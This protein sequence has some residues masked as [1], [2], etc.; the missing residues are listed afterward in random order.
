MTQRPDRAVLALAE[1]CR[2]RDDDLHRAPRSASPAP[3]SLS[4]GRGGFNPPPPPHNGV[5]RSHSQVP[6]D[7][8]APA[9]HIEASHPQSHRDRQSEGDGSEYTAQEMWLASQG[10]N[11]GG[12]GSLGLGFEA[13]GPRG[14][15]TQSRGL[16]TPG[17]GY[18]G[19]RTEPVRHEDG[20]GSGSISAP[21]SPHRLY[22][23]LEMG[24]GPQPSQPNW[25]AT[26]L[27][28]DP[29]HHA[30]A[31][32]PVNPSSSHRLPARAATLATGSSTVPRSDRERD[33][34]LPLPAFSPFSPVGAS[35]T[36]QPLNG[37][38]ASY[39]SPSTLLSPPHDTRALP[40]GNGG[41]GLDVDSLA[42]S[43]GMMGVCP[44][45]KGAED[46]SEARE[47]QVAGNGGPGARAKTSPSQQPAL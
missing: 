8:L 22:A 39:I 10:P 9:P 37:E 32:M 41:P 23:Q 43:F 30:T 20:A 21:L 47:V 15:D 17:G 31:G 46:P 14:R 16:E 34:T 1:L 2:E 11:L 3:R 35:S 44:P 38:P 12:V 4:A 33:P 26:V 19:P 7:R 40:T 29:R 25:P 36:L 42:S 28:Y 18:R 13:T 24:K 27:T 5:W 45:G 6:L